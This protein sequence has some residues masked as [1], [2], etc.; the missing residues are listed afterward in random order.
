MQQAIVLT[1]L[2]LTMAATAIGQQPRAAGKSDVESPPE[3]SMVMSVAELANG[4][5]AVFDARER[6][7]FRLN[8]ADGSVTPIAKSGSGPFEV[9]NP[10]R[11]MPLGGD[12]IGILDIQNLRILVV[13][14]NGQPGAFVPMSGFLGNEGN[15][16]VMGSHLHPALKSV[17]Y[18]D[19]DE[20]G[21]QLVVSQ[22]PAGGWQVVVGS[23]GATSQPRQVSRAA[24]GTAVGRA[25]SASSAPV[26]LFVTEPEI[27][28]ASL[29]GWV[30]L[31]SANPYRVDLMTPD[32]RR[33]VGTP[34][35]VP[36]KPITQATKD[37]L[38]AEFRRTT[39]LPGGQPSFT[40]PELL[41]A[42]R[43]GLSHPIAFA[44]NGRLW[45][46]RL[47][48]GGELP[49][50]DIF[51]REGK[52]VERVTLAAGERLVGIGRAHLYVVA[53]D[54]DDLETVRRIPFRH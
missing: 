14:P 4:Q 34:V 40:W 50:Y 52:L 41:P 54:E 49:L 22:S 44:P 17:T 13:R 38:V 46:R 25:V 9:A 26:N 24:G 3:F 12:S 20:Q 11:L 33:I 7:V 42:F 18:A 2:S 31:V 51:S 1:V 27:W 5:V 35:P 47:V 15:R 16:R 29:D 21:R 6:N 8:F 30:A 48:S 45:V 23:L 28:T 36:P 10:W 37:S 53:L 19:I 32:G 39:T 43:S